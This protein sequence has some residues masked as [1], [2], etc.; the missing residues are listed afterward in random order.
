MPVNKNFRK[1]QQSGANRLGPSHKPAVDPASHAFVE[2]PQCRNG[3]C[4]VTWKPQRPS[5]AA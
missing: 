2:A 1:L 5:N 4:L 3:V